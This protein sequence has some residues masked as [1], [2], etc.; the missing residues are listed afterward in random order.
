M[1]LRRLDELEIYL[2]V[3]ECGSFTAAAG[4]LGMPLATVSRKVRAI[5]DRLGVQLLRR[6]TRRLQI[7]EAGREFYER[8]AQAMG[9]IDNAEAD[10]RSLT[11]APSGTLRVLAPYSIGMLG[12]EPNVEAFQRRHPHVRLCLFLDNQPLDLLQ[13]GFDVAIRRGPVP[14]ST[15]TAR[16]LLRVRPRLAASPAY[17]ARAGRPRHPAE[18]ARHA[19]LATAGDGAPV[20]WAL[21]DA[22]GNTVDI[23]ALPVFAANDPAVVVRQAVRG[24]GIALLAETLLQDALAEGTLEILFPEWHGR[25]DIDYVV[26]FPRRAATDRK[27]R[28][29]IDFLVECFA[30]QAAG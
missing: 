8:C 23:T 1:A 14:D 28:V 29:F 20:H 6:T 19:L 22:A 10:V 16:H 11:S 17:L 4:R 27:V 7:T 5:E 13:H 18:V 24:A 9:Q 26:L 3:V 30:A 12:I 2:R 21:A 25:Q 15:Y